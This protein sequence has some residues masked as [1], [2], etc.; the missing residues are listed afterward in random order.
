MTL[1]ALTLAM[2]A[3]LAPGRDVSRLGVAI[4]DVSHDSPLFA[5]DDGEARTAAF[6]VA[7]AYRESSLRVDAIGDH[8]HSVCAFQ[9][10]D[11]PRSLL[12]DAEACTRTAVVMLRAS[13][14]I[15]P[16]HPLAFYA[17]GPRWTS[18]EARRLS[19]DRVALAKRILARVRSGD[20]S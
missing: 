13:M 3:V 12:S 5:G 14:R 19:D 18:V 1:L 8:G 10:Y 11:G 2:M 16:S 7:I 17:R 20:P 6:L 9:I 15:D 4:A